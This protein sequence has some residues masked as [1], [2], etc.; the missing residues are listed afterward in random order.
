MI[1][2][3]IIKIRLYVV[4]FCCCCR[5]NAPDGDANLYGTHPTYT[6][7][8]EDGNAHAVLFLNSNAQVGGWRGH[9][10]LDFA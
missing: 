7:L 4:P 1:F 9:I 6:V 10:S 2:F 5:D 8:E 3:I